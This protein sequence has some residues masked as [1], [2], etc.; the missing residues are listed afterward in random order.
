MSFYDNAKR[1]CAERGTTVSVVL[2][3]IGRSTA[4][5]GKWKKGVYSSVEIVAQF[6]EYLGVSIDELYYGKPYEEPEVT[7]EQK[8]WLAIIDKIP[9]EKHEM[10]KDF[11][12]THMVDEPAKY[13]D[14]GNA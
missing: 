12:K 7:L 9:K 2:E 14:S 8:D 10:L 3:K 5:T 6:A 4:L 1:I 13:A 11:L